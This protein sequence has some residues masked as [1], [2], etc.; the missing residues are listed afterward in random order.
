MTQVEQR[1]FES[2][3][4][5]VLENRRQETAIFSEGCSILRTFQEIEEERA[6]WRSRLSTFSRGD[7]IVAAIGNDPSWPAFLLACWDKSLVVAPIEP[8]LQ[9]D[10]LHRIFELTRA[11][12]FVQTIEIEHFDRSPIRWDDP[13]PDLLKITSGTTGAP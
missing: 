1:L 2:S 6:A 7:C 11:Q 13:K 4:Q 5:K 10:Q 3:W 12:G 8:T 9:A